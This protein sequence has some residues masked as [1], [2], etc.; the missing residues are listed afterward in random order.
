MWAMFVVSSY[1]SDY[2]VCTSVLKTSSIWQQYWHVLIRMSDCKLLCLDNTNITLPHYA[3]EVIRLL[4]KLQSRY[5]CSV[6]FRRIGC[7][8]WAPSQYKGRLSMLDYDLL[9]SNVWIFIL[10][11]QHLYIEM[12][13]CRSIL[14]MIFGLVQ[15]PNTNCVVIC[16]Y[17]LFRYS[18]NQPNVLLIDYSA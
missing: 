10:V 8:T 18:F 4:N 17:L 11:R 2:S 12:P 13:P 5:A 16:N 7:E 6:Q 3:G 14:L 1:T 9:I 15:I